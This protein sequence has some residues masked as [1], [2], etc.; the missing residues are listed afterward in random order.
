MIESDLDQY[1]DIYELSQTD[2][3][4]AEDV[5]RIPAA[6][7]ENDESLKSLRVKL[8]RLHILRKL[9][10]CSILALDIGESSLF[11][12]WTLVTE[13]MNRVSD[14]SASAA[15]TLDKILSEEQQFPTLESPK[16]TATPRHQRLHAQVRKFTALSQGVRG[17]QAKMQILREES[18][19]SLNSSEEVTD[20]G[21]S[22]LDHY[23][24][25]GADLKSLVQDWEEGRAALTANIDKNER[26]VSQISSGAILSSP[27]TPVSLGGLTAVGESPIGALKTL[28]GESISSASASDEEVFEAIAMP[29]QRPRSTLTRDERIALAREERA[30]QAL[31][32]DKADASRHML[33]ELETVIKMRPRGTT[34]GRM[35]M[36]S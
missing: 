26:R 31:S 14:K 4:E 7:G 25:I 35:S 28:N 23:D 33:K 36:P 17:L 9:Y 32:R 10:L 29:R 5:Q 16:A 20:L 15:A 30:R 1:F 12:G 6:E 19:R 11:P 22:L 13:T 27:T 34:T 18:D 21:S 8:H 2:V 24:A 3:A